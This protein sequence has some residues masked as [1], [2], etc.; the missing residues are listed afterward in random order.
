MLRQ[1][2]YNCSALLCQHLSHYLQTSRQLL[3]LLLYRL[4]VEHCEL[5]ALLPAVDRSIMTALYAQPV[6]E[7]SAYICVGCMGPA[8]GN[9]GCNWACQAPDICHGRGPQFAVQSSTFSA[10]VHSWRMHRTGTTTDACWLRNVV[11]Q[12]LNVALHLNMCAAT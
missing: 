11:R 9:W 10:Q 4:A 5:V 2:T 6:A 3:A 7:D 12:R 1:C 8:P